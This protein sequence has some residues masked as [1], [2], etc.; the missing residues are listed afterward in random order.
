MM[1]L[2]FFPPM[3][4]NQRNE[5][6]G[7]VLFDLWLRLS[8]NNANEFLRFARRANGNDEPTADLQLRHERIGNARTARRNQNRLVWPM[9]APSQSAVE[10]LHGCV[11]DSQ[12]AYSIVR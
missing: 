5:L 4:S 7:T 9:R 3:L 8:L 12:R 10:C 11:I 2:L 6:T 1:Q